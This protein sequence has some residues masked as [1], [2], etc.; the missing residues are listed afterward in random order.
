MVLYLTEDRKESLIKNYHNV[1]PQVSSARSSRRL[2]RSWGVGYR[3][4]LGIL[5]HTCKYLQLWKV[6]QWEV[7]K[8]KCVWQFNA[9][10]VQ[11]KHPKKDVKLLIFFLFVCFIF[12]LIQFHK[13]HDFIAYLWC[14]NWDILKWKIGCFMVWIKNWKVHICVLLLW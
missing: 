8:L 1:L 10:S 11:K 5:M 3:S 4:Y 12:C 2:H 14:Q 9:I 6:F 13:P 7:N